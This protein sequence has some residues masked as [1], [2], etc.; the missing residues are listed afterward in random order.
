M[1][2]GI[3]QA[4]PLL[5]GLSWAARALAFF[6]VLVLLWLGLTVL[7]NAERRPPGAWLAGGG[8]LLGGVCSILRAAAQATLPGESLLADPV[9]AVPPDLWWRLSWLPFAGAA[10]LW[11]V[12][13]SWYAGRLHRDRDRLSVAGLSLLGLWT[14][15]QLVTARPA[16]ASLATALPIGGL[17]VPSAPGDGYIALAA[18]LT[19]SGLCILYGLRALYRPLSR[20]RFMGELAARRARPWLTMTSLVAFALSV[21]VGIGVAGVPLLTPLLVDLLGG[22]LLAAHVAL[23]G[24][25]IVSYEVFTGKVLP[26]RGL[27][28][29]W[30]SALILAGGFGG[31][32]AVSL[33]LPLDQS[34]R[35]TLA[36]VVVAVFYALLSWRSFVERERSL[37]QLRP[38]VASEHLLADL[39][40]P[41]SGPR[42][43][44][45]Q[46]EVRSPPATNERAGMRERA[47]REAARPDPFVA[48]CN[49]LLGARVGYLVPLGPQAELAGGPISAPPSAP[50]P[51]ARLLAKLAAQIAV[52]RPLCL[53][54]DPAQHNGA[55]WAVALWSERG[56]VGLLLL[57]EKQDG[58][59]YTQE[60]LEIARAAGERLLDARAARE[61][62]RRLLLV[63]RTRLA[64]DY[65]QDVRVRRALHDDVLPL[66]HTALLTLSAQPASAPTPDAVESPAALLV[67]AHR[68]IAALLA[69]LPPV[70]ALDA[71]RGG[72]LGALR[73]LVADHGAALDGVEWQL[74]P[75]GEAALAT[76]PPLTAEVV[77][78]AVR[79]AIRNAVRHGRA[80]AVARPLHVWIAV[81]HA[82]PDLLIRIQDDGVGVA[83]DGPPLA[84]PN[85]AATAGS[86]QGLLLHSTL[87]TVLGGSL[88]VE[89]GP[90]QGARVTIR[91]P[92][93]PSAPTAAD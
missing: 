59:L 37:E 49:D 20:D 90:G 55:A 80:G 13:L 12:V 24:Q 45:E 42:S 10:Y 25:A 47:A 82:P 31:V 85:L 56:L 52:G 2:S 38:F 61:L 17:S 77:F 73:R 87:V 5:A 9:A 75:A 91:M 14:L 88:T 48:L 8:L 39:V 18:Y 68:R 69:E 21:V 78:G 53:P 79:E 93:T 19:F 33:G 74:D 15:L 50:P 51:D 23:M 41:A 35:L 46:A 6:N 86:G 54:I 72:L 62:A 28:R 1:L 81:Q 7:L 4:D 83:P 60:E 84:A 34:Y 11:S 3:P 89:S 16:D 70:L 71:T 58:S 65:L 30:R 36:L 29:Y 92:A 40:A 57:G 26:R 64:D 66:L 63:Q 43:P 27:A 76:L 67:D 22:L 32:M 44:W